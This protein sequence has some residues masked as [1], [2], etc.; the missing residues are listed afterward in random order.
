MAYFPEV[1]DTVPYEGPTSDNPLAYKYFSPSREVGGKTMAEHLRFAVAYWH[2][3]RGRGADTF[4]G[5]IHQRA[6]GNESD[7]LEA[8]QSTLTALFE[9]VTKLGISHYCFHDRDV[10]PEGSSPVETQKKL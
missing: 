1:K 9:L 7:P 2:S 5:G 3:M 8:A 4:G 10:A 6:W